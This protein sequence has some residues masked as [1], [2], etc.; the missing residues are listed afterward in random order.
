MTQITD[1]SQLNLNGTYTYADYLIWWFEERIELIKG[2]IYKMSPAPS[3][4]HQEV[5]YNITKKISWFL[6][7]KKCKL[8]Y[9]PFDVR[10][11]R[12]SKENTDKQIVTVVP[13]R[14]L[15]NMRCG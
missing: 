2:K 12:K 10:L 14:Y 8:F 15:C 5:S 11:L 1:I 13:A 7:K 6:N 3:S 4:Y 9:A